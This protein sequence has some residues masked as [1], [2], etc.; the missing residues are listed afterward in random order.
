MKKIAVYARCICGK[1][2]FKWSGSLLTGKHC[3]LA[4]ALLSRF[5]FFYAGER[6]QSGNIAGQREISL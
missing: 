2:C 3:L 5:C 1:A 4:A 6:N